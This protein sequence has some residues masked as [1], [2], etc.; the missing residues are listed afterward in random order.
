M[1]S[2]TP[3]VEK[4]YKLVLWFLPKLAKFPRDQRFL[5]ADRIEVILLDILELLIE[6]VYSK[7]KRNILEKANLRLDQLRFMVRIAKDMKYISLKGYDYFCQLVLEVGR[8]IGGWKKSRN[9]DVQ[10]HQER[11]NVGGGPVGPVS[12]LDR[13]TSRVNSEG[14]PEG[15]SKRGAESS[16]GQEGKKPG[17]GQKRSVC[18]GK[19]GGNWSNDASNSCVSNRSNAANVNSDRNNN[20]GF[21]ACRTSAMLAKISVKTRIYANKGTRINAN[22]VEGMMKSIRNIYNKVISKENLYRAAYMAARGRKYRR[23]T[24]DFSFCLEEEIQQLREELLMKTYRHGRYKLFTIR[25]PK[26]R[27]IAAAPFRDKVVHHA[28]HDVIEPLI[29]KSFIYDSYACRKGKGTHKAVDRAQEFLRANRYCFH[30]DVKKYFPSID[31]GILKGLLRRRIADRDTLWLLEDVINSAVGL[32]AGLPVSRF[33]GLPIGSLTSQFFA[34]LYLNELD[35]YIKFDLRA[36]YY[37]RYM[38]DFLIFHNSKEWI[39]EVKIKIRQF[40]KERLALVLHEGKSQV[41]RSEDGIKFLGFRL[42]KD[43]RRLA[44]DNVRRFKRRLRRFA[45]LLKDGKISAREIRDSIQCWRVH[46]EYAN[47]AGLRKGIAEKIE[48]AGLIG[49]R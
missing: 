41:F 6:A 13:E 35:Y 20:Y 7:E 15:V 2:V 45:Y 26:V 19:R 48:P 25:D 10:G 46:A 33:A 22:K 11:P 1:R 39:K 40:L 12:S 4:H 27:E 30:G 43:Y 28:V 49:R 3:V 44:T 21:R 42:Y 36:R 29:D 34:N 24:A 8:M 37:L 47:T 14:L 16:L 18:A 9:P 17:Q 32:L 5:L 23:T 38:D 31:H